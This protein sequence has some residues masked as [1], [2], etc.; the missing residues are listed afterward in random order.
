MDFIFSM[1]G[2]MLFKLYRHSMANSIE[3]RSPFLD[4]DLV[5]L[6]FNIPA[7]KKIGFLKGKLIIRDCYKNNFTSLTLYIILFRI[8][9]RNIYTDNITIKIQSI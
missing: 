5:N 8:I 3:L 1:L 2:D 7:E 6:S 9:L 4:K